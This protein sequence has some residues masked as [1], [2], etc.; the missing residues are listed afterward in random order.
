MVFDEVDGSGFAF[1]KDEHV[2]EAVI[3]PCKIGVLNGITHVD[4]GVVEVKADLLEVEGLFE[5]G[6]CLTT[7]NRFISNDPDND[8]A[9]SDNPV[10]SFGN[11]LVAKV[12]TLVLS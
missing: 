3:V 11:G 5:A 6:P 10:K 8:A 4:H 2:L 9:G 1:T 12:V 7:A